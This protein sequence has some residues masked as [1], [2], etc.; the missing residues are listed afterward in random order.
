MDTLQSIVGAR[1][2]M[3]RNARG[4]TQEELGG[5]AG[6]DFTTIGGVER[7]EKGLS[8]SSLVRV[9]EALEVQPAWLIRA[10]DNSAGHAEN[11]ELL[12]DLLLAVRDLSRKDLLHVVRLVKLE[13]E[14]VREHER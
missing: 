13:Q 2:R 8:P 11:E 5:R 1:I 7:G 3:L 4:W 14:Y 6:L 9:T 12:Q 10:P